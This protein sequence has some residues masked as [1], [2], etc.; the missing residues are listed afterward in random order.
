MNLN[1]ISG[2]KCIGLAYGLEGGYETSVRSKWLANYRF[3]I[4]ISSI[5][6]L[7]LMCL[8]FSCALSQYQYKIVSSH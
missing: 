6:A 1:V 2:V 8:I 4:I 3:N 7:S 5:L